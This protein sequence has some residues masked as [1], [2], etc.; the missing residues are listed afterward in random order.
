VLSATDLP[1]EP[2]ESFSGFE[3]YT[4]AGQVAIAEPERTE[5]RIRIQRANGETLEYEKR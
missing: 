2:W 1:S 5:L 4:F 3:K